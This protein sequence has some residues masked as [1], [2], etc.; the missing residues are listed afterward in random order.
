MNSKQDVNYQKISTVALVSILSLIASS[1]AYAIKAKHSLVEPV[2]FDIAVV[3]D[4]ENT[5]IEQPDKI[6][7]PALTHKATSVAIQAAQTLPE[8]VGFT[9]VNNAE[10][11]DISNIEQVHISPIPLHTDYQNQ[12]IP[13]IEEAIVFANLTN[14]LPA[15]LNYFTQKKEAQVINF[16]QQAYGQPI[17]QKRQRGY[18][19]LTYQKSD[20]SIQVV[21]SLQKNKRQVDVLVKSTE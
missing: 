15:V 14:E 10:Q 18:L 9:E 19:T 4:I 3:N 20:Q 17:S 2:K 8:E 5:K 21:I 6:E 13:V 16:Y 12:Y 1:S 11:V 7:L